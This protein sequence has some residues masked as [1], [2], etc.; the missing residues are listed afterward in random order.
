MSAAAANLAANR[1]ATPSQGQKRDASE[2][3]SVAGS[4]RKKQ[5]M[6]HYQSPFDVVDDPRSDLVIQVGTGEDIGLVRVLKMFLIVSSPVFKSMLAGEFKEAGKVYDESNPLVLDDDRTAFIDFCVMIH[7]QSKGDKQVPL[8]RAAGVAVI[9]DKYCCTELLLQNVSWPLREYF[10]PSVNKTYLDELR[11]IG[12]RVED[13]MCIS[14]VA[15]DAKL[16][17]RCTKL[18][19]SKITP[20][21]GYKQMKTD[22]ALLALMPDTILEAMQAI[23]SRDL[24]TIDQLTYVPIHEIQLEWLHGEECDLAKE[25][26]CN[27][28]LGLAKIKGSHFRMAASSLSVDAAVSAIAELCNEMKKLVSEECVDTDCNS[29]CATPW[30]NFDESTAAKA[31]ESYVGLCL[32]CIKAGVTSADVCQ[33]DSEQ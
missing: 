2:E 29:S 3:G 17:H 19:A 9:F 21:R 15:G 16:F 1:A 6:S 11:G 13:V 10:G 31:Q 20:G 33:H 28:T 25:S 32:T 27:Y 22:K 12:L 4:T 5:K 23:R 8:S 14:Y 30:A 18:M 26:I 7:N 24:D